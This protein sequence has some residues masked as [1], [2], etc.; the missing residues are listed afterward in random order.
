MTDLQNPMP[1]FQH[2]TGLRRFLWL[3][4]P[5]FL[6]V[7]FA[8]WAANLP[9]VYESRALLVTLNVLFTM[10]TLLF[11][12]YLFARSFLVSAEPALV[13][14]GCGLLALGTTSGLAAVAV[15]YDSNTAVTIYNLGLWIFGLCSFLGAVVSSGRRWRVRV[16]MLWLVGGFSTVLT[17][18]VLIS[19]ATH[20]K[21]LPVFFVQGQGGS[22]I[23]QF[24]LGSA[25]VMLGAT[26]FVMWRTQ[27]LTPSPFLR[28]YAPG[29]A[30]LATGLAGLML[31]M[32]VGSL[33][34]WVSRFSQYL[35]GVYLLIAGLV[36]V[37]DTKGGAISLAAALRDSEALN[38]R[39]LQALPAHIAVLDRQ[40]RIL[41]VNQAWTEFADTNLVKGAPAVGVGSNYLE[42]CRRTVANGET[43]ALGVVAGIEAALGG[44]DT[45]FTLEYPCHSPSEKRWFLMTVVPLG[46]EGGAV[47][48]H[49]NITEQKQAQERLKTILQ[50]KDVLL[51]EVHHRVKNN[52]QII[53]SLVNMHANTL[54][55][56][57]LLAV[58]ASVRDQIR[59]MA[60]V[61]EKLYNSDDLGRVDF[62][63]YARSLL[64]YLWR[65]HGEGAAHVKL[66]LDMDPIMLSLE[67]A[68]PCGLMLN[69]LASNA[70]KHAFQG[71]ADGE[72]SVTLH[73]TSDGSFCLSVKDDGIG[74]PTGLD[75]RQSSSLG[76]KLVQLLAGQ[77]DGAVT[78]RTNSGT[79]TE[80]EVAFGRMPD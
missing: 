70:L 64:D 12:V 43:D 33:L 40:G 77:L 60:L 55:D 6:A 10:L 30:L 3:P 49:L 61:H 75:W 28:W 68:V 74:L 19:V 62:A 7:I 48:T 2:P 80:F 16:P 42:V 58:F 37:R 25:I 9:T 63:A 54:K 32:A 50:E 24:I 38:Q 8:L 52:M 72:I 26:S 46:A 11:V 51:K 17:V 59:A 35:G 57:A 5:L 21:W 23:R 22:P 45:P 27:V 79:G 31:H 34:G 56:P 14:L 41:V 78:V 1:T 67:T 76:L 4:I 73:S 65:A 20:E 13:V 53:S 15:K 69:E 36:A 71:R 39:T 18:I 44:T 29:L 47:I 66:T